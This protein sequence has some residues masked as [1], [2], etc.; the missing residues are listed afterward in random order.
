V[1]PDP[2]F[3]ADQDDVWLHHVIKGKT[4]NAT[5]PYVKPSYIRQTLARVEG[6]PWAGEI[7][8]RLLSRAFD[9]IERATAAAA[10][11]GTTPTIKFRHVI[12]VGVGAV[13]GPNLDIFAEPTDDE[14]H[15]NFVVYTIPEAPQL[16]DV[17]QLTHVVPT[18][19]SHEFLL[20]IAALFSVCPAD[21]ISPLEQLRMQ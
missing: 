11:A 12:Y 15:A 7:S 6:R 17:P 1:Q 20:S 13:R 10:S 3:L 5:A 4:L 9:I 21:D 19:I 2:W 8:G 16:P 14:A 18:K